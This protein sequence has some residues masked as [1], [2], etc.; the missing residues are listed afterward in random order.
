MD[1]DPPHEPRHALWVVQHLLLQ[2]RH[3][4]DSFDLHGL[5]NASRERRARVV[6][7]VVSVASGHAPDQK[8][9]L[10]RLDPSRALRMMLI[11][12]VGVHHLYSHTRSKETSWSGST[13]FVM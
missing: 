12:K 4:R 7:E 10:E 8:L 6:A 3:G 13:G 2:R 1:G 5:A 11:R 9:H